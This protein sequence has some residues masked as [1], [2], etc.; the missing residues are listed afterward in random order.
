MTPNSLWFRRSFLSV[1]FGVLKLQLNLP[2]DTTRHRRCLLQPHAQA[3]AEAPLRRRRATARPPGSHAAAGCI[4]GPGVVWA[5]AAAPGCCMLPPPPDH[6][7]GPHVT[8]SPATPL[9]RRLQSSAQESDASKVFDDILDQVLL[10]F[11]FFVR[12][13]L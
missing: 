1:K 2:G 9:H 8:F 5:V 3:A 4:R 13:C 12:Q 7:A 11:I 6:L 10:C